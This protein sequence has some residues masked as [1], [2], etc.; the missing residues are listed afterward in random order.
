MRGNSLELHQGMFRLD[1]RKKFSK[2]EAG[3]WLRLHREVGKS[4]HLE[5]FKKHGDVALREAV[6]GQY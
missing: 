4:L 6:S 5:G 2:R 1:I 3:L